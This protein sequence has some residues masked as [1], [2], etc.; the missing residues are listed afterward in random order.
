MNK[1]PNTA[2]IT[3]GLFKAPYPVT[4]TGDDGASS[5]SCLLCKV[6]YVVDHNNAGGIPNGFPQTRRSRNLR[7]ATGDSPVCP[8][9]RLSHT[10][11]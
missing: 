8:V 5:L 9:R 4:N 7:R 3:K 10:R 2:F 11:A 6:T 1:T